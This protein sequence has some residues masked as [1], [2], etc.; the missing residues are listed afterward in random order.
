MDFYVDIDKYEKTIIPASYFLQNIEG[1]D[2]ALPKSKM[3]ENL[4]K[5]YRTPFVDVELDARALYVQFPTL[6]DYRLVLIKEDGTREERRLSK[7]IRVD[8]STENTSFFYFNIEKRHL[9]IAKSLYQPEFFV[10]CV[11]NLGYDIVS[12]QEKVAGFDAQVAQDKFL[13]YSYEEMRRVVYDEFFDDTVRPKEKHFDISES[14]IAD[15]E[16]LLSITKITL[17]T[18]EQNSLFN[19]ISSKIKNLKIN[20]I[21]TEQ[22]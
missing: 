16:T 12:F 21:K 15:I 11:K 20:E 17:T 13:Y 6:H 1:G 2:W 22:L 18:Q 5:I 7:V 3:L 8:K 10:S 4:R 19:K 9:I 14:Q